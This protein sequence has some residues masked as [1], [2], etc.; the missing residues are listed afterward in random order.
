MLANNLSG[1]IVPSGGD[2]WI[3]TSGSMTTTKSIA[4]ID[5]GLITLDGTMLVGVTVNG[6]GGGES[7]GNSGFGPS[8]SGA[9]SFGLGIGEITRQGVSYVQYGVS[10]SKLDN[11]HKNGKYIHH[12]DVYWQGNYRG[13]TQSMKNSLSAAKFTKNLGR[14]MMGAG[15]A[16]SLYQY[17]S[18][19]MSGAD[20][21][22]LVGSFLITGSAFIPVVGPFISIGLGIADSFGAFDSIY[23]Y[24]D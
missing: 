9:L 6:G 17:G 14:G 13:V 22:K 2:Y 4:M 5:E 18:S 12:G 16:I 7:I 10:A 15:I 21:A 8:F 11:L 24:F 3:Q 1:T 20:T 23:N 19:D